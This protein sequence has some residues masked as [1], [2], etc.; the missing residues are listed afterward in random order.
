MPR[1][2]GQG[3]AP[4]SRKGN[5]RRT[6][7]RELT[8]A[9]VSRRAHDKSLPVNVRRAY[10]QEEKCRLRRNKQKRSSS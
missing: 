5:K 4:V 9:E 6:E 3:L 1:T 2:D 7:F 10:Q 8:D